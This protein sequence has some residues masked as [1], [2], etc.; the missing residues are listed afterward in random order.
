MK[1][2]L[3]R[4]EGKLAILKDLDTEKNHKKIHIILPNFQA[5][6]ELKTKIIK[7]TTLT[8]EPQH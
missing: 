6:T 8:T 5:R 1:N 3:K 4:C 7:T 2:N